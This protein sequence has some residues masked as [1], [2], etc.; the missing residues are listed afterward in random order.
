MEKSIAALM[1]YYD[2]C[3]SLAGVQ[4]GGREGGMIR[5][6]FL[7]AARSFLTSLSLSVA[8]RPTATSTPSAPRI[9]HN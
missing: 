5:D 4:E 8:E 9:G 2:L 1:F 6:A 7:N 3:W